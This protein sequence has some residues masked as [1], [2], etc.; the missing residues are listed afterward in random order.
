[1]KV[2][3]SLYYYLFC[4]WS[5]KKDEPW[6]AHI[7]AVITM[8]FILYV[9]LISI[10]LILMSVFRNEI[11]DLP[12]LSS[13]MKILIIGGLILVGTINYFLFAHK[14]KHK[15]ILEGYLEMSDN[16]KKKGIIITVIYL[17]VSLAIPLY[18]SLFTLPL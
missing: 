18:I 7:N 17:I 16:R 4:I 5:S 15:R 3:R 13:N 8:S 2:L 14:T 9:N 10:P 12:E 6:N 1:M 11:I